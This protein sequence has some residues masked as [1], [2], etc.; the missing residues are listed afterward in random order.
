MDDFLTAW[1]GDLPEDFGRSLGR[2][3]KEFPESKQ[4]AAANALQNAKSAEFDISKARD[5]LQNRVKNLEL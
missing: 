5:I 1:K 3:L 2:V 4:D